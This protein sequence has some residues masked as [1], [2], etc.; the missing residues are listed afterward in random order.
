[1]AAS[2]IALMQDVTNESRI[3]LYSNVIAPGAPKPMVELVYHYAKHLGLDPLRKEVMLISFDRKKV[4]KGRNGQKDTEVWEKD[5]TVIIN[6]H[7]F[8]KIASREKDF[9]GL[10]SGVVYPGETCRIKADGTVEHEYDVDDRH[11][12]G[13]AKK[14]ADRLLPIGAW[15]SVT[16]MLHGLPV[17]YTK[18]LPFDQVAGW[19]DEWE[20]NA[21]GQGSHKTGRRTLRDIWDQRP[22]WM[23]EKCAIA[24]ACRLAY[25]HAIGR[26]YVAEEVGLVS[27]DNG[28]IEVPDGSMDSSAEVLADVPIVTPETPLLTTPAPVRASEPV[29]TAGT[30]ETSG[31][32]GGADGVPW[33]TEDQP[34]SL[35]ELR[36]RVRQKAGYGTEVKFKG[37]K[38]ITKQDDGS[39][40]IVDK[41]TV[42][43]LNDEGLIGV[44]RGGPVRFDDASADALLIIADTLRD[45]CHPKKQQQGSLL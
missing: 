11:E 40:W 26:V 30:E 44:G 34:P 43:L 13:A 35:D 32:A 6:V 37:R 1:M 22:D 45:L 19:K 8:V 10:L 7:G 41:E 4:T 3:A 36:D 2:T 31:V 25:D 33:T 20:K 39:E 28:G 9:A 21:N 42:L 5:W 15:A 18:Y 17:R 27:N 29:E 12:L 38:F 23:N 16:R 24:F 14:G